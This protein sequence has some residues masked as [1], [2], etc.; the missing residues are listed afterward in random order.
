MLIYKEQFADAWTAKDLHFGNTATSRV[1]GNWIG[2]E[3]GLRDTRDTRLN[4]RGAHAYIKKF[5]Q[6]STGD[7]LS[8]KAEET[9]RSKEKIH[10]LLELPSMLEAIS[11]K[12]QSKFALKRCLVEFEKVEEKS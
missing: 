1:E 11:G 10:Y 5:L 9:K 12:Y 4:G 7:L 2:I 3:V 8:A 6:V